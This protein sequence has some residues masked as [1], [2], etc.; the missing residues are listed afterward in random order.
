MF[1]GL[2]GLHHT[3]LI[4]LLHEYD[5]EKCCFVGLAYDF[6]VLSS[7]IDSAKMD[8]KHLF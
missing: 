8:L 1:P 7:A 3:E 5:I 6:C 2:L 4:D